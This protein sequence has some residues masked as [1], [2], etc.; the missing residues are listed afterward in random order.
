[1]S[2][3]LDLTFATVGGR[4]ALTRRRYRWPLLIGRVFADPRRPGVGAVTLQNAAG[5][6]IPGDM[7]AQR[8]SVVHGASAVLRGQGATTISGI[9]G[10]AVAVEDTELRVDGR[11]CLVF[12]PSPRILTAHARYRQGSRVTVQPGGRAVLCDAVVLHPDLTDEGFG[13]YESLVDICG[14]DG[15]LLARD[16]QL[17]EGLPRVRRAPRAFGTVYVIG[18]APAA[19]ADAIESLAVLDGDRRLY[20]GVSDLPNGCGWAVRIAASDGGVLR[21]ALAAVVTLADAVIPAAR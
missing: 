9:P 7:V 4:T 19:P 6:L 3:A 17:L 13:S 10:G 21:S 20:L 15:A 18:A 16:A 11:S 1:M 8:V 2:V 5:T 14:V 12:D